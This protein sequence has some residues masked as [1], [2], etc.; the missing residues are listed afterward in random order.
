MVDTVLRAC[1][2]RVREIQA[3]V[4]VMIYITTAYQPL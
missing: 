3:A 4:L 2:A 1:D